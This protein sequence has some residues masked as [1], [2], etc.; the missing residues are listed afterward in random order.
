MA[1]GCASAYGVRNVGR[2]AV[3]P[4]TLDALAALVAD[5]TLDVPIAA[6]FPLSEVRAAFEFLEAGHL[7]GKV[8]VT[9]D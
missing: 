9:A 8:V 1:R 2:G 7:R 6:S 4:P 5:G 3:H